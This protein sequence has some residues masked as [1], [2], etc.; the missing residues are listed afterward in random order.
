MKKILITGSTGTVGSI[1]RK[2][3]KHCKLFLLSRR[4]IESLSHNEIFIKSYNLQEKHWWR[5]IDNSIKFDLIIHLAEEVKNDSIDQESII[6]AHIE[7]IQFSKI[8]SKLVIYPIT[9]YIYDKKQSSNS[10]AYTAIKRQV[11]WQFCNDKSVSLPILHPILDV[12][13]GIN[14]FIKLNYKYNFCNI[15]SSFNAF[16]FVLTKK[17]LGLFFNSKINPGIS[18]VYSKHLMISDIF[19]VASNYNCK[20]LSKVFKFILSFFTF[21]P[22]V[23]LLVNGRNINNCFIN[24]E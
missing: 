1:L 19:F 16:I 8:I 9:A 18:N 17:D 22:L 20:S 10:I 14:I 6:K 12:G 24:D 11:M 4:K 15:F 21:I 2:E 5:N 23:Y 13:S 3:L 7:F